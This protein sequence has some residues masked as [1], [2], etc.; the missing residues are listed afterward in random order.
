M[1]NAELYGKGVFTTI[2]MRA[3][4]PF[5]WEKHWRRLVRDAGKVGLD[6]AQHTEEST[7]KAL[8][9]RTI[10]NGRARITFSDESESALWGGDGATSIRLSI[11]TAGQRVIPKSF[12]LTISPFSVNSQSPLSGVKSCNY[13]ENIL[14]LDEARER[15]FAESI[16][17]NERGLVTGGCMANVFWTRGSRLFTPSL[18][19]GCLAGTTRE[20]VLERFDCREAEADVEVLRRADAIYL[21]SAGL[22]I[23]AI[24]EFEGRE[25]RVDEHPIMRALDRM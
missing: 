7:R 11:I 13:L 22:G 15:G 6:L 16:R 20:F 23:A 1:S 5:L 24:S 4:E 18:S 14:A 10:R 21:T 17:L 9:E 19:T 12:R 25:L 8:D 2:A 3:G